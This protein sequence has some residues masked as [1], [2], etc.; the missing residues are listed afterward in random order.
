MYLAVVILCLGLFVSGEIPYT[1]YEYEIDTK[2]PGIKE[3]YV[4]P[5]SV[6]GSIV[7]LH[8]IEDDIW[9]G[10]VKEYIR[11]TVT[12]GDTVGVN[13]SFHVIGTDAF[14][15]D[16]DNFL[17]VNNSEDL[18][19]STEVIF[20]IVL[21]KE[22]G[23]RILS[24]ALPLAV[25]RDK[26][27]EDKNEEEYSP[28]AAIFAGVLVLFIVF[29]ALFIPLVIRAKR[30][31][32]EGKHPF[33][34]G[35]HPSMTNLKEEEV[36]GLPR[37]ESREPN[38]YQNTVFDY[39]DEVRKEKSEFTHDIKA[40]DDKDKVDSFQL[41][42]KSKEDKKS[43]QTEYKSGKGDVKGILKNGNQHKIT[44]ATIEREESKL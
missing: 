4:L 8:S 21:V 38:W 19:V 18:A 44:T 42:K 16:E 11:L 14:M 15:L 39:G 26:R 17:V 23:R 6:Y 7:R 12:R 25:H 9:K 41:N 27:V 33:K 10:E 3:G 24:N 43:A 36:T 5:D 13:T 29:M 30:R 34:L 32:Q 1:N 20:N 40:I 28:G 31:I 37:L 2:P 35:S 22:D